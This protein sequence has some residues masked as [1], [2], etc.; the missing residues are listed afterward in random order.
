MKWS[1]LADIRWKD[2]KSIDREDILNRLGLEE[3]TPTADFMTGLG[4][5]A[6]GV[7]VGAGL[8]LLFAPRP[9]AEMR[10]RLGESLRARG[11][12]MEE[13]ASGG[14]ANVSLDAPGSS[15]RL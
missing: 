4:L 11:E 9:G 3:H 12:R 10:T 15:A 13:E 7:L 1:D 8:G 5:F 14:S 2:L 6:V